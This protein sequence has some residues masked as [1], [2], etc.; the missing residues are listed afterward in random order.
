MPENKNN[1]V[2]MV[3]STVYLPETLHKNLKVWCA[4]NSTSMSDVVR[5]MAHKI[6]K[7]NSN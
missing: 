4:S 2:K 3:R 6:T 5:Q 7:K 1:D